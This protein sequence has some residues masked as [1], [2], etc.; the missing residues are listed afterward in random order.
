MKK[1]VYVV[2]LA[3]LAAVAP[4]SAGDFVAVEDD[5]SFATQ[6]QQILA[7]LN[8]GKRYAEIGREDREKVTNALDRMESVLTRGGSVQALDD[9]EKVSLFN[10]QELV[11]TILTSAS[12]DSRIVCERNKKTGSHRAESE[13]KTIAQRRRERESSQDFLRSRPTIRPVREGG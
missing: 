2:A 10:D 12:E 1:G 8:E 5:T 3:L 13:C 4:V 11:N 7:D 9:R 6:K